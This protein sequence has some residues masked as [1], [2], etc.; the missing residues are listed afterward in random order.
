MNSLI[1]KK[2][3]YI[4]MAFA[5]VLF[6]CSKSSDSTE[7][8]NTDG[9]GQGGSMAKFSISDNYLF[10]INEY[11]LK[12]YDITNSAQPDLLNTV[13]VDFGIETV[14]TLDDFLF[15][16]S[17]NGMHIYDISNP[18][19][20]KY[21]SYYE[22]ITSCDPVVANDS[23]AFVTLN[24]SSTCNWNNGVNRLDILDIT[25]KTNPVLLKSVNM[26]SPKG[27]GLYENFVFVCNGT[28]GVK[29]FDYSNPSYPVQVSAIQGID[30]YDVIIRGSH[31][32]LI[33]T[34]GLFQYEISDVYHINLISNILF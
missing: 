30:A 10:A 12:V 6:S 8:P 21:M 17:V 3:I 18:S 7:T 28:S 33:G 27:L 2:L 5:S 31:M 9:S 24:S 32:F 11:Q 14:F 26:S 29:I 34:D 4:L 13:N 23:L 22:H 20:I 19:N 25:N 15:I 1:M 16:G